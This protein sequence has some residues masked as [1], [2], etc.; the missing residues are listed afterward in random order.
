[1][2]VF[3]IVFAAE[4]NLVKEAPWFGSTG[5]DDGIERELPKYLIEGCRTGVPVGAGSAW[6]RSK[7]SIAS[8]SVVRLWPKG[9]VR[10]VGVVCRD[11]LPRGRAH[12][13][14]PK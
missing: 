11:H 12:D 2:T 8:A 4:D 10:G 3:L 9:D 1:M 6:A 14:Q 7:C 13:H 5:L